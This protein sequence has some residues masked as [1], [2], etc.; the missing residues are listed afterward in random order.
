MRYERTRVQG[1]EGARARGHDG[2]LTEPRTVIYTS[3]SAMK[4]AAA[5]VLIFS[6]AGCNSAPKIQEPD[7]VPDRKKLQNPDTI[8]DFLVEAVK[9]KHY[10][11]A[12][13]S[14][15][16]DMKYEEFYPPF[17][18]Y[19]AFRGLFLK[20]GRRSLVDHVAEKR[21]LARVLGKL[22]ISGEALW[23][24][25]ARREIGMPAVYAAWNPKLV[26]LRLVPEKLSLRRWTGQ[27]LF[28]RLLLRHRLNPSLTVF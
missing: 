2:P 28:V 16:T 11:F 3:H 25:E 13:K 5:L 27:G 15:V 9:C 10:S 14:L 22:H 12:Y 8:V 23:T 7:C 1:Y 4:Y 24:H 26:L 21:S 17:A 6:F 19:Q 18:T 20:A